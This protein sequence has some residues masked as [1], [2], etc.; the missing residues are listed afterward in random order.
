MKILFLFAMMTAS[1]ALAQSPV[2]VIKQSQPEKALILEVLVP[3]TTSEVWRA[4]STSEGLSTWLTP[5]AV[6]DLQ[7][8]GEWTAHYPGGKTGGGNILT[9]IRE[10]E[11]VLAAMAPEQFPTVRRER[12]TVKFQLVDEGK[13][14]LVRLTQTGWKPGEEWDR[15]YDYL[16]KGNAELLEALR[17]RFIEGPIDWVKEWGISK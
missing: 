15:A 12:T 8:G 4:F 9:F 1:T 2:K 14:T 16:A 5:N 10:K 3:A 13:S 6:V 7:T 17:R 11:M